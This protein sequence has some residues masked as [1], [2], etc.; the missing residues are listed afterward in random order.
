MGDPSPEQ[1]ARPPRVAE[2][3]LLRLLPKQDRGP[4]LGDLAEEFARRT[5]TDGVN[6]ARSW[7]WHQFVRSVLPAMRRRLRPSG[8]SRAQNRDIKGQG[9]G[10]TMGTMK[11]TGLWN[12]ARFAMRGLLRAPGFTAITVG[13]L[14]LGIGATTAIFT[15]V[16]GVLL[17]PLPFDDPDELVGV[18][19]RTRTIDEISSTPAQYFTYRD[20][21]RVFEDIGSWNNGQVSVTGLAEPE[22]LSAMWVTAGL[23]PLLR[24]QPVIGRRFSEEDDSP[25]ASQTIMLSHAYWQRQFGADPGVL[26]STLRVDGTQREIIGVLPAA[27]A[28]SRQE[29]AIY[30]PF[31]WDRAEDSRGQFFHRAIARLSA[32]ATVE[33]ASAD[34]DRMLPIWVERFPTNLTLTALEEGR[35]GGYARPLKEDVVGDIGNVLWVL[36]GTVGIVLLIACANVANLFLV[37]SE[38]RQQEVAVRTALGAARGQIARQFLLESLVLGLMGGLAGLGLAFGGVRLLTWMRPESLPRLNEIA[39]DPAVLAFTLG[40]S[41]LSGLLFGMLPVF[42]VGGLDLVS[43]LKEGGRGGSVGKQRHRARNTLVVAQMAL[44][45]VLLAGSGLMIRSFQALRNVDPGFSN[46]EEVLTFRVAI[47]PAEIEDPAE[48]A[49]A[50][51]DMWSRLQEI[52]GVTSVGVSSG[53]P[54]DGSAYEGSVILVEDFPLAPGQPP[55]VRRVKWISEDYFETM[56][57]PVLAGHPIEWSDVHDRAS[58]VVVTENFAEE[59]WPSPAAALGKRIAETSN[60]TGREIIGVVGNVHDGGVSQPAVPTIFWPMAVENQWGEDL[61]VMRSFAF[62][63]RTSRPTPSSLVPDVRAVVR[64]VNP[65]LPLANIRTLDQILAQSMARTS[66]ISVMLAIAAA[67]ALALGLVGI[68]GV[69][70]YVVS[71]RTREIGVRMA[72]GADRRDVSRMVLRQGMI[73]AGIGVVVGLIAAVGLTRVMASF[74]YGVEATDPVTFG[75]VAALLTAVALVASYLPALRAS[76]TDPLEALRFE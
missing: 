37:R 74:L 10:W 71:Q 68:Y 60:P 20:E 33:Q 70:S 6:A 51:E 73:L 27:F 29:A 62:A 19:N 34:V 41:L 5:R 56:Q 72:L 2:A 12:D 46:P 59:Y 22:Q 11:M 1:G 13:T 52:P 76:R 17:K 25:G 57:N 18:W 36:L 53:L 24:V 44:A 15:V 47:P 49:L 31:Q 66:F 43:P 63:V 35:F 30:L 23:L 3:I 8:V 54:M 58:V 75:A 50:Y 65:N 55:P 7:Y 14:A 26:G 39:L 64:A 4:I 38:G 42:R 32:G 16:N 28:L 9:E 61:L 48:V 21:N 45:L 69:I 67:V 40:I